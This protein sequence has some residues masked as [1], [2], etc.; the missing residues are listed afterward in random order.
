[1]LSHLQ[2]HLHVAAAVKY[3]Y[4]TITKNSLETFE[5]SCSGFGYNQEGCVKQVNMDKN[6][7]LGPKSQIK[8]SKV[9]LAPKNQEEEF[10]CDYRISEQS[11]FLVVY[12]VVVES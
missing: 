5:E 6:W 7:L 8:F 9:V 3:S 4:K 2:G 11:C 12:E 1:M 10:S